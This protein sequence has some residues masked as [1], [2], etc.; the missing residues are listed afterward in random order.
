[1]HSAKNKLHILKVDILKSHVT[2]L[3]PKWSF[4]T[5]DNKL[6]KAGRIL[7]CS[8]MRLMHVTLMKH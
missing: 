6:I 3:D 5:R 7:V 2:T 8:S 4:L 1:M